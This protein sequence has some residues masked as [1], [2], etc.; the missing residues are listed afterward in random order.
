MTLTLAELGQMVDASNQA[1]SSDCDVDV[2]DFW[3]DLEEA[4][5]LMEDASRLLGFLGDKTLSHAILDYDRKGMRKMA[6]KLIKFIGKFDGN[7]NGE[8]QK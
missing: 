8:R 3:E 2:V 1:C 7:V 5:K 4:L 6:G